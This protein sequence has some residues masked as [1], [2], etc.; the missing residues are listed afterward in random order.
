MLVQARGQRAGQKQ[1]LQMK[2]KEVSKAAWAQGSFTFCAEGG[3]ARAQGLSSQ[4]AEK[5]SDFFLQI[6]NF[7]L[8]VAAAS[9]DFTGETEVSRAAKA[10]TP[11]V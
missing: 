6:W 1:H 2:N 5:F 9:R 11:L 8:L 3:T 7:S 4:E 10:M